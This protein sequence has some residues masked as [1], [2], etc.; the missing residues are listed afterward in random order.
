ML[1][2]VGFAENIDGIPVREW[3]SEIA[4]K[5]ERQRLRQQITI[6]KKWER[7]RLKPGDLRKNSAILPGLGQLRKKDYVK[8]G[9]FPVLSIGGL[10]TGNSFMKAAK[11]DYGKYANAREIE[12]IEQHWDDV[13][14]NRTLGITFIS[15]GLASWLYNIWDAGHGVDKANKKMFDQMLLT[16]DGQNLEY[17]LCFSF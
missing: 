11:D 6:Y 15:I 9:L 7:I 1:F 14:K 16:Y 5:N 4:R 17:K 12:A 10:L 3:N 8:A 13:Q 2:S